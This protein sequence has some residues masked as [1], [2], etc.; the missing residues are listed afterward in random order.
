MAQ[1]ETWFNQ[2][3]TEPVKVH[4]LD[5]NVFSLDNNGNKV[6]VAVTTNGTAT[7]LSGSVSGLIIRSDG[8]TVSVSGSISGNKA[9]ITIPQAACA[10]PGVVSIVIKLTTGSITTTLCAVVANVYRSSTD[11]NIDP[12]TIMPTIETLIEMIDEAV[13]SIPADY[14]DLVNMVKAIED[15]EPYPINATFTAGYSLNSTGGVFQNGAAQ[16]RITCLPFYDVSDAAYLNIK[17]TNGYRV[18]LCLYSL[19]NDGSFVKFY[20]WFT[21]DTRVMMDNPNFNYVRWSIASVEDASTLTP[22]DANKGTI[23]VESNNYSTILNIR[24][25]NLYDS[26]FTVANFEV[27]G[28][29][30]GGGSTTNDNRIRTIGYIPLHGKRSI[31]YSVNSGYRAWFYAY[32]RD[33]VASDSYLGGTNWVT[34]SGEWVLPDGAGYM[35]AQYASLDD[36]TALTPTNYSKV[37][38]R[39]GTMVH[40]VFPQVSD[41]TRWCAIGD[42]ITYGVISTG[43][44]TNTSQTNQSWVDRVASSL[45]Y[46]LTKYASRGIGFNVTG[47]DPDGSDLPRI[48]FQTLIDRVV[49]L[50]A[51]SFNLIT[52]AV[53]I[54]DYSSSTE[55][56][57]S[58]TTAVTTTISKLA[59]RFPH[60]R[61]IFITPFNA[62]N[63][64]TSSTLFA[65]NY[66]YNGKTLKDVSDTI[67]AA[68]DSCGVECV[69]VSNG[70]VLNKYNIQT[71]LLDNVHPSYY[72]H[73]LLAKGMAGKIFN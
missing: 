48:D 31:H 51:D 47:Q 65:Y 21:E 38:V 23:S 63:H 26:G 49:A 70:F 19:P 17:V 56:L 10:V 58:I 67:K 59:A 35:R 4:Y 14:S 41:V 22:S 44:N 20:G 53:G 12:G 7:T 33:S 73:T 3:L 40:D 57:S 69:E 36:A 18:Y 60:S 25:R 2:D 52:V 11:T 61:I 43:A 28:M 54:N 5:G 71:L 8:G 6:G 24:D 15:F 1:I 39:F 64:G 9:S 16:Y 68:C 72:C 30:Q 50:P 55:P 66:E 29:T 27:G 13:D 46:Q 62:C 37:N 34:K 42:S 32:K 45:G